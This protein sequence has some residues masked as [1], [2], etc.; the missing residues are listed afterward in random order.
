MCTRT[1]NDVYVV[2][3][4]TALHHRGC[5]RYSLR[6]Q[7]CSHWQPQE[8][9]RSNSNGGE[10]EW[11]RFTHFNHGCKTV[12][13]PLILIVVYGGPGLEFRIM[14]EGRTKAAILRIRECAKRK[15]HGH[16]ELEV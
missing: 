16:K 6:N 12:G 9:Q 13:E 11:R 10:L 4:G 14:K 8:E 7:R 1:L 15:R 5:N 2:T 3:C